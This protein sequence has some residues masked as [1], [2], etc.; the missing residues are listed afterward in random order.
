MEQDTVQIISDSGVSNLVEVL[1]ALGLSTLI[2]VLFGYFLKRFESRGK[3]KVFL[4]SLGSIN[5]QE[6][7]F[8]DFDIDFYNT[9]AENK[10]LRKLC[11]QVKSKKVED[12]DPDFVEAKFLD[13]TSM[14]E[15]AEDIDYE[16]FQYLKVLNLPPKSV[17]NKR[18]IVEFESFH[19]RT[20]KDIKEMKLAFVDIKGKIVQKDLGSR[21]IDRYS[22]A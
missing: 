7:V 12:D 9:S 20:V 14:S 4:N 8:L 5:P 11:L 16:K 2:G 3:V 13:I 21:L 18:L 17:V 15:S 10:I 6:M 19:M 22:E 1:R